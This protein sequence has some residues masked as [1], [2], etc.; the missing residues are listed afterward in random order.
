MVRTKKLPYDP[1]QWREIRVSMNYNQVKL[2]G[3]NN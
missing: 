3:E 1:K 2:I